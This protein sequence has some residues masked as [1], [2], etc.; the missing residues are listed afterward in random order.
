MFPNH[1]IKCNYM[2]IQHKRLLAWV[3]VIALFFGMQFAVSHNLI[4]GEPPSISGQLLSG[5]N[6]DLTQLHGKPAVIYFWG[7]WCSI[8]GGM[9]GT[10][11]NISKDY[12]LISL[13]MQSGT[14]S[15][16]AQYMSEQGFSVPTLN[17]EN[18]QFAKIYGLTGVPTIFVLDPE[19]KIRFATMGY[20]TEIGF[21]FR[22]WLAGL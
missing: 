13:A 17:D 21:R 16:V 1:Y 6:F 7:S 11:Q 2:K 12:P 9:Q 14:R 15:E 4:S 18:G 8:C 20:T 19:G 10:V 22:L 3:G 5:E